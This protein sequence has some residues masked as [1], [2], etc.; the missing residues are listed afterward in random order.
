MLLLRRKI[1]KKLKAFKNIAR[2]HHHE[3]HIVTQR[4]EFSKCDLTCMELS[5]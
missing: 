3:R 2:P 5:Q 1:E 4:K